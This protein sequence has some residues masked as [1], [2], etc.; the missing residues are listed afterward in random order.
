MFCRVVKSEIK[1]AR[2]NYEQ[3]LILKSKQNPKI[4]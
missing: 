1:N 3:D 2:L 4:L